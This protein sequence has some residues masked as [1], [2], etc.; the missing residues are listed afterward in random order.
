MYY[1][2]TFYGEKKEF[3]HELLKD[4]KIKKKFKNGEEGENCYSQKNRYFKY[5]NSEF[6]TKKW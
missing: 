4:E 3:M 6:I 2:F 1:G 5:M